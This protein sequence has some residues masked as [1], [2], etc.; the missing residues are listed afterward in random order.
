VTEVNDEVWQRLDAEAG[1]LTR[2]T[3]LRLRWSLGGAFVLAVLAGLLW[4]S[5]LTVP[6][7]GWAS[8]TGYGFS[9]GDHHV[10]YDL[11]ISNDGLT[12]VEVI[13][14]GRSGPGFELRAVRAQLPTT[15]RPGDILEAT[16]IYDITDCAAVPS[17]AW[18]VPVTVSRIWGTATGF[19]LPPTVTAPT[20]PTGMRQYQGRDPYALEWQRGLAEYACNPGQ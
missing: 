6:R 19:V 10:E 20:A 11:K 8:N 17:D 15:L 18:P 3:V 13:G 2:R 14:L 12:P 16:L 4:Q 1:R 9:T 7:L 5:G